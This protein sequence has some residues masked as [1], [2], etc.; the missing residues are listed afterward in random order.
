[1]YAPEPAPALA[2]L[3]D[4]KYSSSFWSS[5]AIQQPFAMVSPDAP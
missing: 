4:N 1:M 3:L 2:I 5:G